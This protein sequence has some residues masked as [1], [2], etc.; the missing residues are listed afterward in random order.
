MFHIFIFRTSFVYICFNLLIATIATTFY[1][2]QFSK[3]NTTDAGRQIYPDLTT[4]TTIYDR[5]FSEHD[6]LMKR[7][8]PG[9]AFLM[10][11]L[12]AVITISIFI[13]TSSRL[14]RRHP[15]YIMCLAAMFVAIGCLICPHFTVVRMLDF[16][17]V[18]I[19]IICALIFDIIGIAWIYGYSSLF[20]DLEFSIGRPIMKLWL[21][22]W[23]II[24][25]ILA[26]I[27]AWWTFMSSEDVIED[28]M[29]RWVPI[30][31]C[32]GFI[33]LLA[34][35]EVSKQVD[36]NLISMIHEATR[37]A[38]D[39]GPGLLS[40]YNYLIVFLIKLFSNCR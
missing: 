9:L 3:Y 5:S 7:L 25:L 29:P 13:Y 28:F 6:V 26:G 22:L 35:Y 8:I 18:G 34:C 32:L 33:I 1:M 30:A 17:I 31:V 24:P 16:R 39:W 37:P 10:I 20:T 12:A 2:T 38:K 11:V 14:M 4:L 23:S 40:F 19:I 15:N 36:Y 27:L 21:V